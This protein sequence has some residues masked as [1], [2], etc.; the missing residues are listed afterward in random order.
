MTTSTNNNTT[1]TLIKGG[2]LINPATGI[3]EQLD[4]LINGTVIE[5]IEKNIDAKKVDNVIELTVDQ[6]VTPGLIDVHVH[7][8]DPGQSAKETTATGAASAIAGGFTTVCVMPNTNPP[9]DNLPAVQYIQNMAEPT[10][11]TILPVPAVSKGLEGKELTPIGTMAQ[12]G[13]VA[14]TDDGM[15]IVNA[16]IMR[17]AL[18]YSTMFN[19]PIVC[20]AED[21]ALC[22]C[23]VMH[24][25][26]YS[27]KL[28]VHGIPSV[29]ESTMVARDILLAQDTGGHVHFAHLSTKESVALVRQAKK[30][31]LKVT[32]ETTPHNLTLTDAAL[33]SY[34]PN[35]KM[36]GPLRSEED[37]QALVEGLQDGTIDCVATD[38]APHTPEEKQMTL[39]DAPRGVIGLET[40]LGVMLTNFHQTGLLKP[41]DIVRL[42]SNGGSDCYRLNEALNSKGSYGVL[43]VGG[44]ADVT[45]IDPNKQ[46]TV[47]ATTFASKARNCPFDGM[48]LT[49]KA[50][51]T[52]ANGAVL[53]SE[54]AGV[55]EKELVTA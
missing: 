39:D 38:H 20:H 15:P 10:G 48:T 7:F 46:W 24:E 51:A 40:S 1:K 30:D 11:I 8:R 19:V 37:R 5:A 26:F 53:M 44:R 17:K 35:F 25:G 47:D 23:G 28:G 50:V 43:E 4:V 27:T 9:I 41:A 18:Q 22:G 52:I 31:G 55:A 21:P 14:F 32:A 34:N 29:A 2:R 16:N 45:I 54:L 42:M 49:G 12:N 6:W 3:D 36:Y 13:A 33:E